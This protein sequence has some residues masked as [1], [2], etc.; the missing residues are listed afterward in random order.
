MLLI[1]R[2]LGE[3][4]TQLELKGDED[5]EAAA[6]DF[7]LGHILLAKF[8]SQKQRIKVG[9]IFNIPVMIDVCGTPF[10]AK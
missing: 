10:L 8:N 2:K 6:T 7:P 3:I 5:T 1:H 9:W 4:R